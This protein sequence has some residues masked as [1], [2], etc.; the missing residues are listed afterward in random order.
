M[1]LIWA[2]K[3][4]YRPTIRHA[5]SAILAVSFGAGTGPPRWPYQKNN[6]NGHPDFDMD[7][8]DL[9]IIKSTVSRNFTLIM[10]NE[11]MDEVRHFYTHMDV[12]KF[13]SNKT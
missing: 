10:P 13:N 8:L 2:V 11:Y 1:P 3:P 5:I 9:I 4:S 6:A 12:I 7:L